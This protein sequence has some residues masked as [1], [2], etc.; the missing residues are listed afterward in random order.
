[1]EV[2]T[3]G[4]QEFIGGESTADWVADNGFSPSSYG[5]NLTKTRGVLNMVEASTDKGGGTLVANVI[6]ATYD[7][8]FAGNDAYFL[9]TSGNFYT[10]RS[11][12]AFTLRQT[13]TADTFSLGTSEILQFTTTAGAP[14]L[15]ASAAQRIIQFTGSNLDG[16]APVT[17]FWTGLQT[18]CRHPL[19]RVEDAMYIGDLNVIH[20]W[21]GTSSTASWVVLPADV[22]ITSLRKHPDGKHLIAFCG[23]QLNASH[24][25]GGGGRIY[26]VDV[27]LR[28]W[29]RE[30]DT[31]MQVEGSRLVGGVVYCTYGQNVGYFDGDGVVLLKRLFNSTTTYSHNI[32]NMDDILC[33]RDGKHVR[34]FGDLGAGR[35]WW[36]S[37]RTNSDTDDDIN[38]LIN[39]G[40]NKLLIAYRD[41]STVPFLK[42]CDFDNV[43][44]S[45]GIFFS[46]R[47]LFPR[48]I[49]LRRIEILHDNAAG[50]FA[51]TIVDL[52]DA[53]VTLSEIITTIATAT[54]TKRNLNAKVDALQFRCGHGPGEIKQI[55]IFY[56]YIK[57]K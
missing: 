33:I 38:C 43:S 7:T 55:R 50:T 52:T 16:A 37:M 8:S 31:E 44:G 11:D 1:M 48:Q 22:N 5:L 24:T 53:T 4:P 42:Q 17:D 26:I 36:R 15:Y 27:N 32:G 19:E 23:I 34:M 28:D 10:L 21:D 25:R 29:V 12:D 40:D 46:K 6:A 3:I 39:R 41:T 18:N 13:I 9:D 20:K 47:Y 56:D 49:L 35:V 2:L 51:F 54:K 30:I 57:S 45:V 14:F